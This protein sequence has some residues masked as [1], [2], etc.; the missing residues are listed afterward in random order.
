M[1]IDDNYRLLKSPMKIGSTELKNRWI[2]LAMHNGFATDSGR[3]NDRELIFYEKRAKGGVSAVTLVIAISDIGALYKMHS[4]ENNEIVSSLTDLCKM[5]H[6]YDCKVIVQLFHSGRNNTIENLGG[7][8]PIAPSPIESPIYKTVPKEMDE[9]DIIRTINEFRNAASICKKCGVDIVE[10]SASVGYLL[11]QFFSERTNKRSDKW[12]GNAEK[13][14]LFPTEV[15]KAIREE[16]GKDYPVTIKISAG[17]MLGGYDIDYMISF[18][19]SLPYGYLN[20]IVVTGGWHEAPVPQMTY[21]VKPG[22]FALLAKTIKTG[23]NLPVISCNRN[24]SHDIAEKILLEGCCDFVGVARPLLTDYDFVNKGFSNSPYRKCQACNKGCIEKIIHEQEICCAF[25]P[26]AGKEYLIDGKQTTDPKNI[27]VIGGGPT[28]MEAALL[29]KKTGH[30]VTLLEKENKLGGKL[31]VASMPPD[32]Q[33]IGLFTDYMSNCLLEN[34]VKVI[35]NADIEQESLE[36]FDLVVLATGS[37][38]KKIGL[39]EKGSIKTATAED[40]L[41]G[42]YE[43]LPEKIAII[44]GGTVGIETASYIKT[45]D[46]SKQITIIEA[47]NK[48]GSGYGGVKWIETGR[49]KKLGIDVKT[50]TSVIHCDSEGLIISENEKESRLDVDLVVSAVGYSPNIDEKLLN[51]IANLDINVHRIG[52]C[53]QVGNVMTGQLDALSL[54]LSLLT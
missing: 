12:G 37:V 52:D 47:Q 13:R 23:T 42:L 18:I 5:I 44:G 26:E 17:D 19:N 50:N 22:E 45:L 35:L 6:Q 4:F 30:S 28:G 9:N 24:N 32:K 21:H 43:N 41:G 38:P 53:N 25:N 39:L 54:A 14:M 11:A 7:K 36:K 48:I 16:V 27:L 1:A 40:I 15:V 3:F 31:N 2:M 20:G 46:M 34:N 51:Q 33:D 8:R 29:L 49:I 10:I